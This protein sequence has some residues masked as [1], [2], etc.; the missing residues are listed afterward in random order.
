MAKSQENGSERIQELPEMFVV[1]NEDRISQIE[2]CFTQRELHEAMGKQT[3]LKIVEGMSKLIVK[4]W[5]KTHYLESTISSVIENKEIHEEYVKEAEWK[6]SEKSKRIDYLQLRLH[7]NETEMNRLRGINAG[8]KLSEE[9]AHQRAHEISVQ[10]KHVSETVDRMAANHSESLLEREEREAALICKNSVL[11]DKLACLT[12][13]KELNQAKINNLQ[14]NVEEL[15]EENR[16]MK[17]EKSKRIDYLQ[18]QLHENETEMNRLWGINAGLKLSEEEAHQ[19]GHEI[20]VKLKHVSETADRMAANHSEALWEC[21]KKEA[22]LVSVLSDKLAC[23]TSEKELNQ[24]KINNLQANVEELIEENRTMK[25]Q[26]LIAEMDHIKVTENTDSSENHTNESL[27]VTTPVDQTQ[28]T[29]ENQTEQ[30]L[31][32]E[33]VE[34]P[35]DPTE[36]TPEDPTEETPENPREETPENP[37]EE[38]PEN[39]MEETP[40]NPMEETPEN[41]MEETPENQRKETPEDATETPK[42]QAEETPQDQRKKTPEDATDETPEDATDETPEDATEETPEDATEETPE[43]QAEETPVR[44][45]SWSGFAKG[46]LKVGLHVGVCIAFTLVQQQLTSTLMPNGCSSDFNYGQSNCL[47]RLPQQF[48]GFQ[49]VSPP[50]F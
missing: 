26:S 4:D 22:A 35:E 13:E 46:L 15:I 23:L 33:K 32:D 2:A 50:P 5:R 43:D 3:K 27:P 16:T 14:A 9:E 1:Q 17:S 6:L 25:N 37:M 40:E 44:A 41:P 47:L 48:F 42:N 34:T 21:K 19:R 30:T 18:L 31:E 20:S 38:T 36:E 45:R 29:S 10:L 8:L 11:S 7:E 28:K 12:S 49:Y 24:A 39:P